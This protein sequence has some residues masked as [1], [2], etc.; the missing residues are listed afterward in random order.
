MCEFCRQNPC[1][2]GCPNYEE[3]Q[4]YIYCDICEE[5]IINGDEFIEN[6]FGKYAHAD[7]LDRD[8]LKWLGIDIKT[9]SDE[10]WV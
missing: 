1:P 5:G 10:E 9:L 3:P 8:S 2:I 7:C 4:A 6:D